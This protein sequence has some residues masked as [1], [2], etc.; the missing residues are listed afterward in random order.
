MKRSADFQRVQGSGRRLRGPQ[1]SL[2]YAPGTGEVTR[3]GWAVRRAVGPAVERNRVK[4]WLREILRVEPS[5][6][7][8]PWDLVFIPQ[9][10]VLEGG[11]QAVRAQTRDLLRRV[12]R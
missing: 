8:G 5:P 2:V 1:L 3:A 12:R 6:A 7:G 10:G 9:V 4:R 11:F